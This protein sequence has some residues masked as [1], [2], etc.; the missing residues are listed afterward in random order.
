MNS[1][2]KS[3]ILK[4]VTIFSCLFAMIS[5]AFGVIAS[6][7][8]SIE[9]TASFGEWI[10]LINLIKYDVWQASEA[11]IIISIIILSLI[12][13][14][15][16]LQFFMTNKILNIVIRILSIVGMLTVLLSFVLLLA[17][18]IDLTKDLNTNNLIPAVG[19]WLFV[20]FGLLGS[21]LGI[22]CGNKIKTAKRKR[23]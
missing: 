9:E 13:I 15:V 7:E 22:A 5:L 20:I 19:Q 4:S 18:C 1:K 10:D 23:K 21:G 11:F 2:I 3:I 17:G 6:T 12:I 16:V 8:T 14:G